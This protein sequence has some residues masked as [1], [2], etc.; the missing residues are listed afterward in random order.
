MPTSR[1]LRRAVPVLAA[2]PM[3][4]SAAP[5]DAMVSS[6]NVGASREGGVTCYVNLRYPSLN[7]VIVQPPTMS[8][9]VVQGGGTFTVGGGYYGGGYHVQHVGY[10]AYLYRWN[11]SAWTYTGVAGGLHT[12]QTADALQPVGWSDGNGSSV[13]STP[14]HG[15]YKVYLRF[16]W[17]ADS[18]SAG[19]SASGWS[20]VYE[21]GR[22]SYCAF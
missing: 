15:Y 21:Q 9:S 11:G 22:Q 2:V 6:G 8:S 10:R 14:G 19:G 16:Y 7:R 13:F 20:N 3:L 18:Q 12:G 5:A 4:M 1:L 17:Y